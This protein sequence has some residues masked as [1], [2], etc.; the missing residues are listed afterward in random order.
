MRNRVLSFLIQLNNLNDLKIDVT[1]DR[2]PRP[3]KLEAIGVQLGPYTVA[4]TDYCLTARVYNRIFKVGR[5]IMDLAGAE[6]ILS[7]HVSQAIQCCSLDR[8]LWV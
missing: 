1:P 8:Q 2:H 3:K 6:K 5:T 4:M 7:D